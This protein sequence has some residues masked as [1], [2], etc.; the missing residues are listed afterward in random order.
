M[1]KNIKKI[2]HSNKGFTLL[3]MVIV[4]GLVTV[5]FTTIALVI[6]TWYQAYIK[7]ININYA[8]Q[9]STSV[10][11]AIEQ[12]VRFANKV[13]IIEPTEEDP[14]QR[15]VGKN[16]TIRFSIPMEDTQNQIDGLVYDEDYFMKNDM[17]LSFE[18]ADDKSYCMIHVLI[19]RDGKKVLE[20]S[21]AVSLV[22]ENG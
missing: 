20:K 13:D 4:V 17:K 16:G 14:V 10:V 21:R 15:L 11:G 12:T 18:L 6:P 3:E 2:I 7:S 5:M 8:R 1:G 9:I 19:S 22:G